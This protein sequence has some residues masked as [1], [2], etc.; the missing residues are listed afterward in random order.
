MSF[1]YNDQFCLLSSDAQCFYDIQNNL[2]APLEASSWTL[3]NGIT[4]GDFNGTW[5]T[6]TTASTVISDNP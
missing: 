5:T 2:A 3:R 4:D 1:T 6:A